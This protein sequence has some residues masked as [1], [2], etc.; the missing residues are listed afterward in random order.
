MTKKRMVS[1]FAK[2]R[3]RDWECV[4]GKVDE[5]GLG[6]EMQMGSEL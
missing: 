1:L 4:W 2:T 6:C 3:K 5:F